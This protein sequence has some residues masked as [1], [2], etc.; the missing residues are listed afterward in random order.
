M[1]KKLMM[2]D[3]LYDADI[4]ICETIKGKTHYYDAKLAP[5]VENQDGVVVTIVLEKGEELTLKQVMKGER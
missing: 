3:L 5:S 2:S 1:T 4:V